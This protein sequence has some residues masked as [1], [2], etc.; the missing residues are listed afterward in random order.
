MQEFDVTNGWA[1][2]RE[3]ILGSGRVLTLAAVVFTTFGGVASANEVLC[4][5]GMQPAN[6][7]AVSCGDYG[8]LNVDNTEPYT[9]INLVNSADSL[10]GQ[11]Y[12][13]QA[14]GITDHPNTGGYPLSNLQNRNQ[15]IVTGHLTGLYDPALYFND[16]LIPFDAHLTDVRMRCAT[17]DDPGSAPAPGGTPPD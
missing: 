3:T 11:D 12:F 16:A 4:D 15:G 1:L 13:C 5:S 7:Q 14:D 17:F 10:N 6:G 2:T 8:F 9:Q